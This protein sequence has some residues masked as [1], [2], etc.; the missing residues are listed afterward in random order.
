VS[1]VISS[2]LPII[3]AQGVLA[4]RQNA[5][6]S[7]LVNRDYQNLAAEKGDS[8]NVPI[9]S[10]LAASDVVP[11][12]TVVTS[13][14]ISPTKAVVTLDF[15]KRSAFTMTDKNI[16]EA[17]SGVVPM[18]MSEAIKSIGNAID[19]YIIGKT[20]GF[21]GFCGTPATTPFNT[22]LTIAGTARK[23]LNKQLAPMDERRGVL[24]PDAESNFLL[25]TN[26]INADQ[27]GDQS[28]IVEGRI[29]RTLGLDW[30]MDQNVSQYT[31]GAGWVTGFVLS[32]VGAAVGD[33]TLN[34]LNATASGT[35]KVGDVFTVSGST[36]SYVVTASVTASATVQVA[37]A[38]QPALVSAAIT[39]AAITVVSTAFVQNLAFHRNAL[40]W[41][42]R[43]MAN[44]GLGN[45]VMSDVD[46][47][48]GVALR[49]EVSRQHYQT[50]WA[51]DVLGGANVIRRE[52]GV[53]IAG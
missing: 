22:S 23:L 45:L 19:T 12:Y 51:F 32:T 18:Q 4:L 34:I 30:Y 9:P 33:T 39:G 29:A 43:P 10:A 28:G 46:P 24:D 50:T 11:G 36:Q 1:N 37:I 25:N 3:Y 13:T 14:D 20:V 40:A 48:S 41:V 42:S 7:R 27:R 8:I 53:R 31:P 38:F 26:I 15:W 2:V 5:V 17:L 44:D 52:Y 21:Q 49:L 47:I 6:M 16:A 35:I